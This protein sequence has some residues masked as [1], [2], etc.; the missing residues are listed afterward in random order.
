[1][2]AEWYLLR[3][4]KPLGPYR[5][6][7]IRSWV[8]SGQVQPGT[9]LAPVGGQEWQP[10]ESWPEF[11]EGIRLAVPAPVAAP[12]VADGLG[13]WITRAWEAVISDAST[14]ILATLLLMLVSMLSFG[15]CGP[16]LNIGLYR[17]A[18]RKLDGQKI[19]TSNLWE[20]FSY[21]GRAWGLTLLTSIPIL[22]MYV[23]YMMWFVKSIA[24][25]QQ[26][27]QHELPPAIALLEGLIYIVSYLMAT[28]LLFAQP[29]IADDRAGVW[30]AIVQSW[31]TVKANFLIYL[32]ATII[33]LLIMQIGSL[34]CC[35]GVL[36]TFPLSFLCI[37]AAYRSAFPA[38][39]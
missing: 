34:A 9:L 13:A 21:F 11:A 28:I 8:Q 16:P 7:D 1:M 36:F 31:T 19:S 26:P 32:V 33:F 14:F 18:L 3:E 10:L 15:I 17:M 24:A 39:R 25:G 22:I 2:P 4:G 37:A 27:W 30:D 35:V 20:G 12:P 38:K 29:L 6:E 5:T 23:P